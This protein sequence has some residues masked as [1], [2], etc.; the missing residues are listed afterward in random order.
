[1]RRVMDAFDKLGIGLGA[2]FRHMQ[3]MHSDTGA[4]AVIHEGGDCTTGHD[5]SCQADGP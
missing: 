2:Y 5:D 3:Q 4:Y 1:M